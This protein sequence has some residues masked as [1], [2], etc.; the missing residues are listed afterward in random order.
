MKPIYKTVR[1]IDDVATGALVA[2]LRKAAK[3]SQTDL[4]KAMGFSETS[5]HLS[6]L[7]SGNR[8]WSEERFQEAIKQINKLK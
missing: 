6:G 5:S 4:S 8:G 3:V 7:E 2:K 1:E